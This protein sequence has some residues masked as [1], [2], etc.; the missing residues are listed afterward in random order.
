MRAVT[1]LARKMKPLGQSVVRRQLVHITLAWVSTD[2]AG[3]R[4]II[5]DML[6]LLEHLGYNDNTV[7]NRARAYLAGESGPNNC[8]HCEARMP[9]TYRGWTISPPDYPAPWTAVSPDYD[10]SYEGPED[11]WVDNGQK[12][13][14]PTREALIQ[15]IDAWFA[16]NEPD[17]R[18]I[19]AA[20]CGLGN[21][22]YA[23]ADRVIAAL[24]GAGLSIA[25][26]ALTNVSLR[27]ET[28]DAPL[29][30]RECPHAPDG[31]HQVDT[32][33]ESGPDNCFFCEK[34]MPRHTLDDLAQGGA[35][36]WHPGDEA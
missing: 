29:I 22:P 9:D 19:I 33:M 10:A 12:A 24:Q 30:E 27:A 28:T 6:S 34:P 23:I 32:S 17:A 2:M 5:A 4:Y 14:A 3:A 21:S 26:A 11:G 13:D 25:R 15:E 35:Y 31:R 18:E 16:E 36:G 7:T 8:F 1:K 20:N